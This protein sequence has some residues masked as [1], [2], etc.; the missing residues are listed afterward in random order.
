MATSDATFA[1]ITTATSLYSES[2]DFIMWDK[3][4]GPSNPTCRPLI[5]LTPIAVLFTCPLSCFS[6]PMINVQKKRWTAIAFYLCTEKLR[7]EWL[8]QAF[9]SYLQ[10]TDEALQ[11][12]SGQ[13]YC[14]PHGCRWMLQHSAEAEYREDI[15]SWHDH[16]LWYL[17]A[18]CH[19]PA[20]Q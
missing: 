1:P 11:R 20:Y 13:L 10:E 15:L 4:T 17:S 6:T 8:W 7:A 12:R 14:K 5:K 18:F 16:Y 9:G 19:P 3:S 2:S